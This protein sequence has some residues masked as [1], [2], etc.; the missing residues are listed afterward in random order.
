MTE[1]FHLAVIYKSSLVG[2]V[3]SF[4]KMELLLLLLFGGFRTRMGHGLGKG[5][6]AAYGISITTTENLASSFM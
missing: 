6:V 3:H 2:T 5:L 1:R 4:G